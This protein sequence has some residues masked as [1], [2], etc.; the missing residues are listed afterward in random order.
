MYVA[1]PS[2]VHDRKTTIRTMRETA[3]RG[4]PGP[5]AAAAAGRAAAASIRSRMR[6]RA[7]RNSPAARAA[8]TRNTAAAGRPYR[9]TRKIAAGAP[10]AKPRLPPT[11]KS[12]IPVARLSATTQAVDLN[13]SGWKAAVPRPVNMT[14]ATTH[15]KPGANGSS[16]I[17]TPETRQPRGRRTGNGRRSVT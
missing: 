11:E 6:G 7:G 4:R 8:G 13:P 12:D 5:F 9:D 17:P 10:T 16:A 1:R 15:R 2:W 14:A 3:Y